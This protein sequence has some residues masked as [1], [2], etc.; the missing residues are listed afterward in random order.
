MRHTIIIA[1]LSSVAASVLTTMVI[2]GS[3]FGA[4]TARSADTPGALEVA[5]QPG[6]VESILQ[7]DINCDGVVDAKDALGDLRFVG[8]LD[9]EQNDPCPDVGTLAAIP[10]P[11]GPPGP[12]GEQGPPGISEL[13]LVFEESD[14]N[15]D[16]SKFKHAAC[17][18]G[19]RVLGGGVSTSVEA[20][21]AHPDLA[22][23]QDS[24]PDYN[25]G[26]WFGQVREVTA[27]AEDW[28]FSVFAI[29]AN[30]AE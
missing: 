27:T 3:L 22:F 30:V 2:G 23:A 26:F 20:Q 24:T 13:E 12:A 7:G 18:E 11:A 25:L 8:G 17:P 9:V 5:I 6:G 16:E 10:R 19:K 14:S 15:S 21:P 28:S 4:D 1:T 29:C